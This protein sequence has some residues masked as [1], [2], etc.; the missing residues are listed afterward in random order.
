MGGEQ[1]IGDCVEAN[2]SAFIFFLSRGR[3][4]TDPKI[5]PNVCPDKM[6]GGI[7]HQLAA[8]RNN[9]QRAYDWKLIQG[10]II[11]RMD[12]LPMA[13][14]WCEA[15]LDDVKGLY[16]LHKTMDGRFI[17]DFSETKGRLFFQSVWEFNRLTK[18]P[19]GKY[20]EEWKGFE[21]LY[22]RYEYNF[23]EAGEIIQKNTG[24]W[25]FYEF[26]TGPINALREE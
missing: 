5:P 6:I 12:L 8:F 17:F 22:H 23:E 19:P 9:V 3:Y 26:D 15:T 1:I 20:P 11:N 24:T 7:D 21:H 25:T 13:H 4:P 18:V 10:T 2:T 14:S 16:K